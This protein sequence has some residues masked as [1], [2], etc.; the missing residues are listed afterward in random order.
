MKFQNL[1]LHLKQIAATLAVGFVL[2]GCSKENENLSV[3][4]SSQINST[5]TISSTPSSTASS[6]LEQENQ[7]ETLDTEEFDY[8]DQAKKEIKELIESEQ[9][10]QAKEKGKEYFITGVDFI[11]YDKEINGVTFDDLTEEGKKVTLENLETI[12][13]WIM[14]IAPDYKDKISEKYQVVKD[15]VSTT[16]YDVLESIKESLGEENYSAIQEKKNEIKDSITST[17]DK[18]LEKVSE[19]YQNFK[20]K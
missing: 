16:Y 17:K 2:V 6:N 5:S 11:F 19:W 1:S 4:S 14:E 12:D 13:G 18:A 10:E 9:V 3:S 7:E 8:F 20:N 15:F